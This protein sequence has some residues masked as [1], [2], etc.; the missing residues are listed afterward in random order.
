M[1]NSD[2]YFSHSSWMSTFFAGF[3]Y[4]NETIYSYERFPW[5]ENQ[6][7]EL[8]MS[9]PRDMLSDISRAL[10]LETSVQGTMN[11]YLASFPNLPELVRDQAS[12]DLHAKII[13]IV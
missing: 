10:Y 6:E 3:L 8:V 9:V 11:D 4:L 13:G 7:I 2:D 1:N 12:Y 5:P